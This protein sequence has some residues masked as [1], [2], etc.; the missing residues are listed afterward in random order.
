MNPIYDECDK[1]SIDRVLLLRYNANFIYVS[2]SWPNA[3]L[4]VFSTHLYD[5][6]I[7]RHGAVMDLHTLY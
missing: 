3:A 2:I 7:R 1:R 5:K 4:F 6:L